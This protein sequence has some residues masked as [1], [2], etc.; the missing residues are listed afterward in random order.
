M[1]TKAITLSGRGATVADVAAVAR[2]RAPVALS[3][4]ARARVVAARAVV[5]RLTASGAA[6]YGVTTALSANAAT[7]GHASLV[8]EDC[9]HALDALNVATALTFEGFRA[10]LSPLDPRV[11]KARPARGQ[12][13]I[14]QRL[15]TLLAGSALWKPG[16]ARRV[17]DP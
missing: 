6:Y 16:A 4:E 9:A 17:Q 3:S 2:R 11:Q 15:T 7:V 5:D 14:A 12:A 13:P 8:L 10:N 1:A